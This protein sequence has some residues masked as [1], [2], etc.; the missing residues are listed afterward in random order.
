MEHSDCQKP[1]RSGTVDLRK[2]AL[3]TR[4]LY[5]PEAVLVVTFGALIVVG[6]ILL[7]LPASHAGQTVGLL[8]AFFT[9][10]SAVCVTGLITVDTA[11]AYTRFGQLVILALIQLGGLGIM[12][13]G[14]LAAQVFSRRISFTSQAA[15]HSA[16]FENQTRGDLRR[17]LYQIVLLTLVFEACGSG[18]LY[19]G[20]RRCGGLSA[21]AGFEAVFHAISAFCN[22]GFSVRSDNVAGLRGSGLIV[23]TLMV[24]IVAGG[25]GYTVW[26]EV[27]RRAWGRLRRRRV[28]TVLWSLHSRIV[29]GASVV[30]IV[31]GALVLYLLGFE[32]AGGSR[33]AQVAYA[34][35]QSVTAR[36]AGFNTV[37]IGALPVAALLLIAGLMFIGGSPGSCAGGIKTTTG[38]VWLARVRA[39][40]AGHAEVTLGQRRLPQDVV[41]RASL[42]IAVAMLWNLVGVMLLS[43]TEGGPGGVRFEHLLFEQVSAFATVGLS[44]GTTPQLSDLGKLWI[45]MTMFVGRLGPLTIALAVLA[46]PRALYGHP[47]ERVM[48][49]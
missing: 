23:G 17:A 46:Q 16:L 33:G 28:G 43:I 34:L 1:C 37:D 35:F 45:I 5:R 10:T 38:A 7:R 32:E 19:V 49:G 27:L 26:L 6:T 22:A 2:Q 9:A 41:R 11:T 12:T 42:V 20:L 30:L 44:A 24:L 47:S 3:R 39:R 21:E 14:A 13:F 15:L 48:I 4:V 25:L 8:D 31:G 18:L 40:L 29:L 36:T